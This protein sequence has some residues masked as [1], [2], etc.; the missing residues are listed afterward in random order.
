M[1][2]GLHRENGMSNPFVP[3]GPLP[4]AAARLKPSRYRSTRSRGLR[5]AP[6]L[7]IAPVPPIPPDRSASGCTLLEVL[8]ATTCLVVALVFVAQVYGVVAQATRRAAAITRATILAQDKIEELVSRAASD[9]SLA[10]SPP[11][12]LASDV[13][14]CFDIVGGFVR[15]WSI[16]ALAAAPSSALVIQVVVSTPE[17]RA[18]AL[19]AR[20]STGAHL[21]T[22]RRK[23]S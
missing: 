5:V 3:P 18:A 6:I 9:A 7:P 10:E 16:E 23:T 17:Q 1:D 14:G 2:R 20:P 13:A 12:A 21:V 11:G 4:R 22:V 8:V 19:P 15:R